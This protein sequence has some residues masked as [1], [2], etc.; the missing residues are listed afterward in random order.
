MDK[1][2]NQS[3]GTFEPEYVLMKNPFFGVPKEKRKE[4]LEWMSKKSEE[5]YEE[6]LKELK[7]YIKNFDIL[8]MLCHFSMYHLSAPIGV[9]PRIKDPIVQFHVELLQALA[10]Q[11]DEEDREIKPF[12]GKNAVKIEKLI[13]KISISLINKRIANINADDEK[14]FKK[15]LNIELFRTQ[16]M[17]V[18]NWGY[19]EQVLR[20]TKDLFKPIDNII[21]KELNISIIKLIE[22]VESLLNHLEYK[23]NEKTKAMSK[24]FHSKNINEMVDIFTEYYSFGEK[25]KLLNMATK[26]PSK[27]DFANYLIFVLG[28][29]LNSFIYMF[30][31]ADCIRFYP[32]EVDENILNNILDSWSHEIGELKEFNTDF[33]FF[34]NPIW[35]KPLIKLNKNSYCW[36]I[37]GTFFS[38]CIELMEN[39]IQDNKRLKEIY[40]R[41]KGTF[42]ENNVENLFRKFF[43]NA[44]VY[45]KLERVDI[46][47]ET[48]LLVIVDT[49]VFIIESKSGKIS[50]SARRGASKTLKREIKKLLIDSSEQATK[51]ADYIKNKLGVLEFTN[52]KKDKVIIDFSNVKHI[53]T[54]S[55]TF[56]LFGPIAS[57]TPILLEASLVDD[58]LDISPSMTLADLEMLFE[59]LETDSEKIHYFA[60]RSQLDKNT[61]YNADEPDLL[62]F[63]LKTGFNIVKTEFDEMPLELY[64]ESEE[65]FNDYYLNKN[66]VDNNIIPKPRPRRT[67]W[68]QDII[69]KV[70]ATKNPCW[71]EVAVQLLNIAYEDQIKFEEGIEKVKKIVNKD[72]KIPEHINQV[73]L[74]NELGGHEELLVGYCYKN[75]NIYEKNEM[76]DRAGIEAISQTG[77]NPA[78]IMGFDVE[79]INYPYTNLGWIVKK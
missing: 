29:Q 66:H 71:T 11:I 8:E 30:E 53:Y 57:R 68:W 60:R 67:R 36:P 64:G 17:S 4:F 27:E 13:K 49:Y 52:K 75:M 33:I 62:A 63:Y 5:D 38:F 3:D 26:A 73:I 72:W 1:S 77:I 44:K 70:E 18:R 79:N 12:L 21:E 37:P 58:K 40:E 48:D 19:P 31:L 25:E 35:D 59:I 47:G 34:G 69:N 16:N 46:D 9:S 56:D 55:V 20:L 76:I 42:L 14:E 61:I 23:L 24:I 43:K 15:L 10:L 32:G 54:F 78:L 28:D 74:T 41:R 22:M 51:L 7:D 50:A 39:I 6:S 45:P 2:S 65:V